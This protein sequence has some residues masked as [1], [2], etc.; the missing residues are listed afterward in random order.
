MQDFKNGF[1]EAI[2]GLIGA[3]VYSAFLASLS[4]DKT[5]PHDYF[6]VFPLIS[7]AG[8]ISTIFIFKTAGFLFNIGVIVGALLLKDAMDTG[9]FLLYFGAPL[10]ILV[11]RIYFLFKPRNG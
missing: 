3:I 2:S 11:L 5:I 6:W 10:G 1:I 7:L 4:Q 8:T 9:T